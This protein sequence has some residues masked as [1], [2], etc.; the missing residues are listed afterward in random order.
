MPGALAWEIDANRSVSAGTLSPVQRRI[1]LVITDLKIGGTPTV[2]RELAARLG[3][4]PDVHVQVACLDRDGP[5]GDQ[6][7]EKGI[8]VTAFAARGRAD[9][10]ILPRLVKLIRREQIDT[11]FS[12]LVHAN[13]LAAAASLRCKG[14]RFIQSIQTTQPYPRWHWWVQRAA[15]HAAQKVVVTSSSVAQIAEQRAD[16]PREKIVVIHNALDPQTFGQISREEGSGRRVGFIGRLDPVKRIG[17]LIQAVSMLPTDTTLDI[18][19]EGA[20][21]SAIEAEITRFNLNNRMILHGAIAD[22]AQALR[23]I[24][25]L[26]LPSLAEGFGLVLIEAMAAGV[27]VIGTDVGG[28]RDVIRDGD[29]GLLVP[30]KNPAEIAA[31]ISKIFADS[32]LRRRLVAGGRAT[33]QERFTWETVMPAYRRVLG[34][35]QVP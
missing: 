7:R 21:R 4:E 14:V 22:P 2:V 35:E 17:D 25:L 24:D 26:V 30:V 20:E 1:L 6:I 23:K 34:L 33:V 12:F 28:I 29:N 10:S 27:P 8:A 31:A 32:A 3:Q 15:A 18:F 19:G 13:A 5:V 16:V 9:L 11:V